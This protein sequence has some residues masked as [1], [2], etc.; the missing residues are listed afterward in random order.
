MPEPR[1]RLFR[2]LAAGCYGISLL[3]YPVALFLPVVLFALEVFP[4]R[5]ATLSISDW[6]GSG[7]GR[8]WRDKIPF[9]A[10]AAGGLALTFW[11]RTT[12]GAYN[13]TAT[14]EQSSL[15]SR[16]MQGFYVWTYY[17]WKPWAPFDQRPAW[18]QMNSIFSTT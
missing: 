5:R 1:R 18:H 9:L 14:L 10:L 13:S 2:W 8:M 11:A 4:L 12:D 3:V 17:V 6:F 15:L 16:A 7:A